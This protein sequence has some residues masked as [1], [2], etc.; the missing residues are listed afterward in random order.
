MQ[1][2]LKRYELVGADAALPVHV[3]D[4]ESF[5]NWFTGYFFPDCPM[6]VLITSGAGIDP[7]VASRV[8]AE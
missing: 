2:F 4:V 6:Q 1:L 8:C 7:R 5:G 3:V